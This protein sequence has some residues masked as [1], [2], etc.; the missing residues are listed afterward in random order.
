MG[1]GIQEYPLLLHRE[2]QQKESHN[3]TNEN[4]KGMVNNGK[5]HPNTKGLYKPISYVKSP[6]GRLGKNVSSAIEKIS[7]DTQDGYQPNVYKKGRNQLDGNNQSKRIPS[8]CSSLHSAQGPKRSPPERRQNE[9][10]LHRSPPERRQNQSFLHRSPP[11]RRQNESLLHR[12]PPERRQNE[13]FL[14]RIPAG[15]KGSTQENFCRAKDVSV[16]HFY[17]SKKEQ[18][19]RNHE[20]YMAEASPG[21]SKWQEASVSQMFLDF[22]S[23]QIIKE[24][25]EDDSASD[26]SDSERIPIPPS[27]CTPPELIL[28]AEEIDPVC[29]EHIPEMGFKESEYYY[30]DFLPPPFNSWDLKQLAT[31]VHVEGKSDFRPRPTG[32]LEKFMERLLQLEWLQLQTVQSERGRATKARPQ[33][34]P[35]PSRALKSPGKGKALLSPVPSRQAVP[36]DSVTRL[37]RSS[38]GHRAELCPEQARQVRSHAGHL[39]VPE[40]MGCAASSQRQTGDGRSELK[41]KPAAKEHLLSL[42]PPESSS[43]IQSVGNIRPPKQTPAFNG[44]AAPIKGLKTYVC[45]N[46]KKNGNASSYVPPKKPTVDRKIK[47]NGT[48]QM[49]RKF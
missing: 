18:L 15:T 33:T 46:P 44:A 25:A 21:S 26:L 28:R 43:K 14:H 34:A 3:H 29:L 24:D 47:T 13:S 48:K 17:C 42:Q 1:P 8:V 2:T 4:Y 40:R 36:Q 31:F 12:S 16:Q 37:P 7:H 11:E 9:S 38:L 10:L 39:K 45:T 41:K 49:P 30:P 19:G 22:E 20:E 27:P 35:G 23:V 6:P 5:S 32:S